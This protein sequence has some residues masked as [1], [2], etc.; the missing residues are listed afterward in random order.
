MIQVFTAAPWW[1]WWG[2]ETGSL[3]LETR[4]RLCWS[5]QEMMGGGSRSLRE[6]ANRTWG[7]GS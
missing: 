3:E 7:E 5:R 4:A 2:E 6:C 1:L